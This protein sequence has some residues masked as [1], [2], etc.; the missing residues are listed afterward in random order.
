MG[1]KQQIES[2][3]KTALLGNDK[4]TVTTL[5][6]LKAA[7]LDVEVSTGMRSAGLNDSE[8]GKIVL[9]EI[10]KRQESLDLYQ[11]NNRPELAEN[12]QAEIDVLQNYAPKQLSESEL[13]S[14]IDTV[15]E[16][17]P[18]ATMQD[19]GKV[20]SEVKNQVGS[21]ADGAL[22]AKLVKAKLQ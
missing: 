16:S 2:D 5:R 17:F 4:P 9:K 14:V 6:G 8:I 19:M 15:F 18:N 7:I 12:E 21:S 1:L 10:K 3:L 11:Q 22:I 13:N 20:I